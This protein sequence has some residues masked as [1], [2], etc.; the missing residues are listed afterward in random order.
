LKPGLAACTALIAACG[1]GSDYGGGGS[2]SM[3]IYYQNCRY[4]SETVYSCQVV[5]TCDLS[6]ICAGGMLAC[7]PGMTT[8]EPC[9]PACQPGAPYL[10]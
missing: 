10:P 1:G 6:D 2:S 5:A 7:T 3:A 8:C 9:S 4:T